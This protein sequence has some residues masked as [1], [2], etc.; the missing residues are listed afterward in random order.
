MGVVCLQLRT[1]LRHGILSQTLLATPALPARVH[2]RSFVGKRGAVCLFVPT[3]A[4]HAPG[5][6]FGVVKNK[7]LVWYDQIY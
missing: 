1:F 5:I 3:A 2:D 6:P 7:Y 4:C